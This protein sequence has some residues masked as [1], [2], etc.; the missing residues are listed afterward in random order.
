MTVK[1][2]RPNLIDWLLR[3][4]GKK[5]GVIIPMKTYE[6]NRQHIYAVGMKECVLKALLRPS[7]ESLPDG[8]IDIFEYSNLPEE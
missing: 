8:L 3:A 1:L 6:I 4:I 7:G 2:P 5:R